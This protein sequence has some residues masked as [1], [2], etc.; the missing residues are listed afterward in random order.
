[1]AGG[2]RRESPQKGA[3]KSSAATESSDVAPGDMSPTLVQDPSFAHSAT[4]AR[5]ATT[6]S[7]YTPTIGG[8]DARDGSDRGGGGDD[9]DVPEDDDDADDV[10]PSF[11]WNIEGVEG[12]DEREK[13]HVKA[14]YALL[15]NWLHEREYTSAILTKA[16]YDAHVNLLLQLQQGVT[17]CCEVYKS[18]N[19]NAY[20]WAK[21]YHLFTFGVESAVLVH[22]PDPEKGAVDVMAMALTSL[23][24]PTYAE[25]L[26]TD[27][28]KLH[29]D[30]HCKG[31]TF[32]F[33]VRDAYGNVTRDVCKLFTDV[34]PHCVVAQT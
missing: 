31:N 2:A 16:E 6:A 7:E 5:N 22:R 28:W 20:K 11:N 4:A 14:F 10:D 9:E 26:F 30:D 29:K 18:G 27:L 24:K 12:L 33:R 3:G 15:K 25:R 1:M 34:C 32:Y 19:I 21:K 17:D 8:V 13:R 23:Q